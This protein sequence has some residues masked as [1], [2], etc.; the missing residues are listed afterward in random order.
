MIFFTSDTHFGHANI[1][2][3]SERPF[4]SREDM[5]EKLAMLW[6]CYVTDSDVVYHLGDVTLGNQR[7]AREYFAKLN[8]RIKVLGNKWHHDKRWLKNSDVHQM[9]SNSLYRVEILPPIVVL[10]WPQIIVLSHYPMAEWDRKHYGSWHLHGHS[11][12][13]HVANPGELKMDVGVDCNNYTPVSIH[14]VVERM[15]EIEQQKD[16]NSI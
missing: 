6:N 3:Y 11:H 15:R 8:G 16:S 5:D 9:Y 7:H 13:K 10:T 1:I 14:Q 12:C 4:A 2:K